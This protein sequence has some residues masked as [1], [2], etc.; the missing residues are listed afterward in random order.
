MP[1]MAPGQPGLRQRSGDPLLEK[2]HFVNDAGPVVFGPLAERA[3]PNQ[4][5][6]VVVCAEVHRPRMGNFNGYHGDAC[7][8]KSRRNHRSH[9]FIRL[10]LDGDIHFLA[11]QQVGIAKR[12][13]RA[14]AVVHFD[15]IHTVRG[16]CLPYPV[17][18]CLGK[19]RC[20]G[21]RSEAD[22]EPPLSFG[23]PQ[24]ATILVRAR[25]LDE[26][27]FLESS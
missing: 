19:R 11:D 6:L 13:L 9:V 21:L 14:V 15:Q 26:P 5:G 2:D 20:R 12:S 24:Q 18:D 23:S 8:Q 4:A 27:A 25:L 17:G 10:E 16:G 3:A 1:V 7:R 22:A